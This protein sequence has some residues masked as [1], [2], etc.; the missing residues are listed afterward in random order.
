MRVHLLL[1]LLLS[2]GCAWEAGEGF[3]V[4]EPSVRAEYTPI[5][6]RDAGNGYQRLSSDYQV[7]LTTAQARLERIELL[8]SASASGPST[9]DPANPPPGYTI[10]HN[11]HCDREDGALVP[12][13]EVE[14]EL[15]GGGATAST[16]ASLPV[17]D[18]DL[19][20]PETRTPACEP[21][22]E[23]PRTNLSRAKWTVTSLRLEGTVRDGR[24]TPRFSGERPF[25]LELTTSGPHADPVA[26]LTG[27][28]D[29]PSDREHDPRVLLALGLQL[30]PAVFDPLDWA[31]ATPDPN[32]TVDL[33]S[34]ANDAVRAE[35][36]ESLSEQSPQTEV[37]REA[38]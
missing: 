37:Q 30:T 23:L 12:Y 8:G 25:R 32:G 14:A 21:D 31:A 18:V 4:L 6:S 33:S 13:D 29:V 2:T 17:G 5:S 38:R 24:A 11:G 28:L 3:A 20:A 35:L 16:V 22:C 34:P 36:L 1:P 27:A 26:V 9:F 10:C 19:L 7:R 15:S